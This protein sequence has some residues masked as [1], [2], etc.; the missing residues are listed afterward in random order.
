MK[1]NLFK[2]IVSFTLRS[3]L[4]A[5]CFLLYAQST[6]LYAGLPGK[7]NY[8]GKLKEN[9]EP[10][11]GTKKMEF[12]IYPAI[13][14][15]IPLWSSDPQNVLITNGL[16]N[17]QL[18]SNKSLLESEIE[19]NKET[20]Y[21]EVTVE[22]VILSPREELTGVA[23]SL[24]AARACALTAPDGEPKDAVYVDNEGNVG[25]G[26]TEPLAKLTVNGPIIRRVA[27]ATEL[28]PADDENNGRI[29]NRVLNFT[30]LYEDTA[31]RIFYCD[32]LRVRSTSAAS[33]W[34]IRIDDVVPPGGAIFQSKYSSSGDDHDPT[35]IFGYATGLPAGNHQIQIWVGPISGYAS[36]AHT[37]WNNSRWT[38]EAQE[39][40]IQ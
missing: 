19:W 13:E 30:K 29:E 35:T 2:E 15:G 1:K 16:F 37:G 33:R 31:I 14:G 8:Q 9:G 18:G 26:T 24:S 10:V 3:M 12:K 17:Y 11:N 34:E 38:I 28:G 6:L 4:L 5:L 25:I 39:V 21:L 7:I 36:D 20:Y 23:Y 27:I 40:W 32:T 22:G